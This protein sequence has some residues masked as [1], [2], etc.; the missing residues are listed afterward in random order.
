[1][2]EA[3][4][5]ERT[6]SDAAEASDDLRHVRVMTWNIHGGVGCDFACDLDRVLAVVRAHDPDVVALQEIDART[7]RKRSAA[8]FDLLAET[9]GNHRAEARLITAPDG[10][11]G[12][13]LISRWPMAGI[14]QHDISV[15]RREPRA[16]IEATIETPFGRLHVVAVH[17]GLGLGE[18]RRQGDRLAALAR[19][20]GTPS[21][22]LGDFNDWAW[23]GSV[24]RALSRFNPDR[25][26]QRTF[27]SPLP[28][29]AIDR[30]YG[31]PAGI[32][33]RSWT[34][35]SAWRASDHLPLIAELAISRL[36]PR[37]AVDDLASAAA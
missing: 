6:A 30:I 24:Q 18:R 4:I 29:F 9:L 37:A 11:Y 16:A 5:A 23:R 28:L 31:R 26:F 14:A 36:L 35:A 1:M 13:A 3:T 20:G 17:L 8:A 33:A 22:I 12:H 19:A 32:I 7:R 2:L 27:P 34:D 25:T 15:G 10:D 21:I